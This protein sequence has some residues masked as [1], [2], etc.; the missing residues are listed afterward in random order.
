VQLIGVLGNGVE[1]SETGTVEIV[2]RPVLAFCPSFVTTVA[3]VIQVRVF[4]GQ[5][6]ELG[7]GSMV[8]NLEVVFAAH[9]VLMARAVGAMS[10]KILP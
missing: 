10:K 9:L 6:R 7:L 4:A 8:I 3:A 1:K 5:L 2:A